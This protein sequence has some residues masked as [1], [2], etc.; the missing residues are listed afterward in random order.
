MSAT[1]WPDGVGGERQECFDDDGVGFE[2]DQGGDIDE[3][4]RRTEGCGF[5]Q[6][7][8]DEAEQMRSPSI[9]EYAVPDV[10]Q[11]F[12]QHGAEV[13]PR[14]RHHTVAAEEHEPGAARVND[15]RNHLEDVDQVNALFTE[16]RIAER[17][18]RQGDQH[19]TDRQNPEAAAALSFVGAAGM[20]NR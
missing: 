3:E 17:A 12:D 15:R 8:V 2:Q 4:L 11:V 9:R 5:F 13:H 7:A 14:Q 6:A 10:A 20:A 19:E 16:Q 18:Q 1:A